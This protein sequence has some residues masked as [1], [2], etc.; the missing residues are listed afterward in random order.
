M[1]QQAA[2]IL[3]RARERASAAREQHA[4][5]RMSWEAATAAISA[6]AAR[7]ESEAEI[8]GPAGVNLKDAP[9]ADET[10]RKLA[11]GGFAVDWVERP[12]ARPGE[13]KF[14]LLLIRW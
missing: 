13:P 14:W 1:T 4:S 8:E 9:T 2:T 7:G 3:K 6:A 11:A 5:E 10:A 12:P